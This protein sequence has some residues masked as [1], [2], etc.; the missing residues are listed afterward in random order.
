MQTRWATHPKIF[1]PVR[2]YAGSQLPITNAN[3]L[4]M[5]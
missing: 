2:F 1:L 5:K 3:I 4:G